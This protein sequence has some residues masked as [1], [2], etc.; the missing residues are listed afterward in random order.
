AALYTTAMAVALC[1]GG[2]RLGRR[3]GAAAARHGSLVS[4]RHAQRAGVRTGVGTL[5][6]ALLWLDAPSG[7]PTARRQLALTIVLFLLTFLTASRAGW[8]ALF[9]AAWMMAL[10]RWPMV[11]SRSGLL[12]VAGMALLLLAVLLLALR[13]APIHLNWAVPAFSR[14]WDSSN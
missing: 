3:P 12:L 6:H 10:R 2:S 8:V 14:V 13:W 5:Y 9:I 4:C 7:S 1:R 11:F